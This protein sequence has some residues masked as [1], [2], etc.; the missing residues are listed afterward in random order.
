MAETPNFDSIAEDLL[1]LATGASGK[2]N[3]THATIVESLRLVWN[4]RGAADIAKLEAEI[5][6]VWTAAAPAG[7]LTRALR[8]LDR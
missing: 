3:Y 7:P 2:P 1:K 5:P 8:G 4:A 6:R